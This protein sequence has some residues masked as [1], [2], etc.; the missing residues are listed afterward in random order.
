MKLQKVEK[1]DRYVF[2][3]IKI[4][5]CLFTL[6]IRFKKLHSMNCEWCMTDDAFYL[7]EFMYAYSAVS[8]Y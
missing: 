1:L 2:S 3:S 7:L 8:M 4:Y 5:K 6:V